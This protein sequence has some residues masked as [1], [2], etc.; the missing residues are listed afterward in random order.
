MPL[1]T[2]GFCFDVVPENSLLVF[3][4][5]PTRLASHG[6]GLAFDTLVRL[7]VSV[8]PSICS[9]EATAIYGTHLHQ[10]RRNTTHF[11]RCILPITERC[12][13][14]LRQSKLD[15]GRL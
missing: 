1:S 3:S 4:A 2:I 7:V 13:G 10:Q 15:D 11:Q 12:L 5:G 9:F 6:A 8:C 14:Q